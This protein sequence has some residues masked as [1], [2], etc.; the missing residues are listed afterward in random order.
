MSEHQT[1]KRRVRYFVNY[2]PGYSHRMNNTETF[3]LLR[4]AK[5]FA[6]TL[7]TQGRG[8]E[9]VRWEDKG[10]GITCDAQTIQV[11]SNCYAFNR[12]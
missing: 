7:H 9:I 3:A 5:A 11:P 6:A 1:L 12:R 10:R 8:Y 4:D 2:G